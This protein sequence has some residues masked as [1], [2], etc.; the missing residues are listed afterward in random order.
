[1][2]L[3]TFTACLA[4]IGTIGCRKEDPSQKALSGRRMAEAQVL[5]LATTILPPGPTSS[6]Y[7][8]SFKEGIWEVSC[9]S[10]HIWKG[11]TVHDADGKI[12]QVNRP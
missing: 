1:M 9:E 11:V 12:E 8:V 10:N 6:Q 5:S 2:R 3:S 4:V 7:H